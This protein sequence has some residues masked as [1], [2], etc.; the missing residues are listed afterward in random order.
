[1]V[2]WHTHSII[3]QVCLTLSHVTLFFIIWSWSSEWLSFVC[4][5]YIWWWLLQLYIHSIWKL[6]IHI[7]H[8]EF[9]FESVIQSKF[10]ACS[11][12]NQC[13]VHIQQHWRGFRTRAL[14]RQKLKVLLYVRLNCFTPYT[15]TDLDT[16]LRFNIMCSSLKVLTVFGI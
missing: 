3:P 16:L 11:Y 6:I 12:L 2:P 15:E 5:L 1:M 13:A 14:V 10:F 7:F 9:W 8:K 4:Q